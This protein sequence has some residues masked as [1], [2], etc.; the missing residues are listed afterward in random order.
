MKISRLQEIVYLFRNT[1]FAEV[2]AS[3]GKNVY[4]G[5]RIVIEPSCKILFFVILVLSLLSCKKAKETAPDSNTGAAT[6]FELNE[7]YNRLDDVGRLVDD[8]LKQ[9]ENNNKL[10]QTAS[11]S[12]PTVCWDSLA[13]DTIKHIITLYFNG[14]VCSL[15][16]RTRSGQ[17]MI[18]Y[19]PG[20]KYTEE[21]F[22][23][24]VTLK[25]FSIDNLFLQGARTVE[26]TGS[27]SLGNVNYTITESNVNIL[28]PDST[29]NTW[30]SVRSRSWN[31]N[32][33]PASFWDDSWT[34]N[35]N[36]NGTQRNGKEYAVTFNNV[37]TKAACIAEGIYCPV[38][39][40]EPII[41]PDGKL[42]VD[43]GDG[44]CDKSVKITTS[45]ETYDFSFP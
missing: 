10:R 36:A 23:A 18:N 9:E 14:T 30:S 24:T 25:N 42:T 7:V 20:K 8:A 3:R 41:I 21:G 6:T 4:V 34:I 39:G 35:G 22:S 32:G 33:S 45:K 5:C 40:Q 13:H 37:L 17:L 15:D 28:F 1:A 44:S 16:Q 26:N 11:Q 27:D 31:L 43:F 12:S 38:Q 2:F 29:H 19:A